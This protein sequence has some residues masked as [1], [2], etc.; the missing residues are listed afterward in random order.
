MRRPRRPVAVRRLHARPDDSP[1]TVG[2]GD[3]FDFVVEVG[4]FNVDQCVF[5]LGPVSTGVR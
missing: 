3:R 5:F 2:A 1:A 4:E